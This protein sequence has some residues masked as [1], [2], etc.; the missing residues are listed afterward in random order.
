MSDE[1]LEHPEEENPD[2][3][4]TKLVA[5]ALTKDQICCHLRIDPEFVDAAEWTY[6]QALRSAAISYICRHCAITTIEVDKSD[7]L[8]IA[9]LVLISDMYD[10]RGRYVDSAHLNRTVETILS[11]YDRNFIGSLEDEEVEDASGRL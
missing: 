11:H 6:I 2:Q 4:E 1:P 5:S 3:D 10:E 9:T 8:A 7:E